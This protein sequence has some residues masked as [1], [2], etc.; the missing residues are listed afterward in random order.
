MN[1]VL[2]VNVEHLSE[3]IDCKI[4]TEIIKYLDPTH[5]EL[6]E[7]RH[8]AVVKYFLKREYPYFKRVDGVPFVEDVED[9]ILIASLLLH[10]SCVKIKDLAIRGT[11]CQNLEQQDQRAIM[12]FINSLMK[13]VNITERNL[14]NSI[15]GT[16]LHLQ[17]LRNEV[18]IKQ[19]NLLQKYY[20]KCHRS[21]LS[22]KLTI[23]IE[24]TYKLANI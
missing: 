9:I 18:S 14:I 19:S 4:L 20:L 21:V 7:C 6:D 11:M 13:H 8:V 5:D 10:F 16:F 17:V 24:I 23:T 1:C 2:N 15:R 22:D 3:L 12:Q